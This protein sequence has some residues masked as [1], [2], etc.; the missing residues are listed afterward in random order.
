[1]KQKTFTLWDT[2]KNQRLL[3]EGKRIYKKIL[4]WLLYYPVQ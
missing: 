1:M 3:E 2:E 4:F